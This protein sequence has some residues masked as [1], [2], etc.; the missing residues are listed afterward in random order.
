MVFDCTFARILA[1]L[2]MTVDHVGA[3]LV[4]PRFGYAA[5]YFMRVA[6]RL[7]FPLF[8]FGVAVGWRKTSSRSRYFARMV[9]FSFV[10]EVPHLMCADMAH[11]SLTLDVGFTFV[12]GM[13]CLWLLETLD[14]WVGGACAALLCVV[15][16]PFVMYGAYGVV[17]VVLLWLATGERMRDVWWAAACVWSYVMAGSVLQMW[18]LAGVALCRL[19]DVD[20][21][22]RRLSRLFV[23]GYYPVHLF[24]IW[25]VGTCLA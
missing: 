20:V 8:A 17:L 6:G 13:A 2:F 22:G 16:A 11:L 9:A 25:V 24:A 23:W 3:Y 10:S 12:V 7:A 18:A 1:L 5:A 21:R 15:S 19:V 4:A 14:V